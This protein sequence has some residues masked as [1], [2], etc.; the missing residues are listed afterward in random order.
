[1]DKARHIENVLDYAGSRVFVSLPMRGH[2]D[3]EIKARQVEIIELL[4]SIDP[5]THILTYTLWQEPA[6]NPRNQ[7]WYLGKSIQALGDSDFA[8]F[9]CDWAK[10]K[11]C[12]VERAICSV[13]GIPIIDEQDLFEYVNL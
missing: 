3:D 2:T 1:M 6:P 7:L 11:G 10:A 5:K 4:N 13:Y 8:I 9:A 12:I